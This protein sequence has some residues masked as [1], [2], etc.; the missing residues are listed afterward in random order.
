M[1][2]AEMDLKAVSEY[3]FGRLKDVRPVTVNVGSQDYA[4]RADGTLGD[5]VRALAPQ[6]NKPTFNVQT[7]SALAALYAAEVDDFPGTCAL[8]VADYLTVELVSVKADEFGHRHVFAQAK[9][10]QE[11][12]FLFNE[13]MPAEKFLIALRTSFLFND[14]AV[15]VQQLCSNLDSGMTV[16]VADDGVSQ[17]LEVK[18]G[19][20]S[21]SG[22]VIPA[23]GIAL[24]PWRTFRDAAPV[25]SKFLLRLK[26]VKDGLPLVA[27]FDIDQKWKLDTTNSIAD[28]LRKNVPAATVIA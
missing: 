16:N 5:A 2:G 27:L 26:G 12:P 6:W 24:I 7:L 20:S 25:E 17:S 15:K 28:W 21:K 22:V 11:T 13:Y 19:T 3:L 10:Q 4:V 8:H 9:H 14:N 1:K 23:E 18:A